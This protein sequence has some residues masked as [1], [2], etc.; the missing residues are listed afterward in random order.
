MVEADAAPHSR[1]RGAV[2]EDE[3]LFRGLLEHYLGQHPG[4]EV[5]GSYADGESAL[6]EVPGCRPDVVTLDIELPGRLDG[7]QLGLALRR[8]VPGLGIVVLSNHGDPRFVAA[9]PREVK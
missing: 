6:A 5:V 9:L 1:V 2:V 3:P 8:Q 4:L 7:I